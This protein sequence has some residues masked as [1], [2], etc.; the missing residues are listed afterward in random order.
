MTQ[1]KKNFMAFSQGNVSSEGE[2]AKLYVGVG[3]VF[4]KAINPTKAKLAEVYGRD[5]DKDPEYLGEVDFNGVKIQTVRIE[6]LSVTDPE[7]ND[8]IE[9]VVRPAITIRNQRRLNGDG[10]K[11]QVVDEYGRFAWVTLEQAEKHEI[12][13]YKNGPANITANYRDAYPGEEQLVNT[14]K[15]YLN[16]PNPMKY[17]NNEWVMIEHPEDA[18]ARLDHIADYFKGDFS[19]LQQLL[20][21]QPNNKMKI[22]FGVRTTDD[23]KQ[24]QAF[25]MDMVL[26][27]GVTDYSRLDKDLQE[28]KEAASESSALKNTYFEVCPLKEYEVK[29]TQIEAA[30][31]A[32]A[33]PASWLRK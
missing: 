7:K 6:F 15:A 33:A 16:I 21:Y 19:E 30:P 5:Q 13:I 29:P 22:L 14:I 31:V 24:Y 27:N 10:T 28:R 18:E 11:V 12:P 17:V 32:P 4:V 25:Y 26:K 20:Q 2:G 9:K 8:G 23:N 3:S 1:L